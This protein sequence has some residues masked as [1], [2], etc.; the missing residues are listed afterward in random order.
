MPYSGFEPKIIRVQ[1]E[2]HIHHT[3]WEA[4]N[5]FYALNIQIIVLS[6]IECIYLGIHRVQCIGAGGRHPVWHGR[7]VGRPS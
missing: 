5:I 2:V 6:T 4:L 1:A 7:R 3:G